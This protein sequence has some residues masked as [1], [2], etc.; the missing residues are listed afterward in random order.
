M[1]KIDRRDFLKSVALGGAVLA[2]GEALAP[3]PVDAAAADG[4][5]E[6]LWLGHCTFRITSV[7]G[8]VMVMEPFLKTNPRTPAIS[9]LRMAVS[10]RLKLPCA[11]S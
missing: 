10:L 3:R 6:V 4:Q 8:K 2:I 11:M 1:I 7:T 5:V 9:A